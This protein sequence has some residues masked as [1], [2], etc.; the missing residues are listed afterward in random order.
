MT[1]AAPTVDGA[2]L[3]EARAAHAARP[4]DAA[5]LFRLACLLL[6]RADPEAAALLPA[7]ERFPGFAPGW[8]ALGGTLLR[9]GRAEAALLAFARAAAAAPRLA[10]ARR[11][12]AAALAALGRTAEAAEAAARAATL[13]P[14]D[15]EAWF[16]L[17][18]LRQDLG[19]PQAA[20]AAYAEALRLR[21]ALH[22]AAFN[23]G[24][25]LCDAGALEA[26]LDAFGAAFRSRP[27]S[28]GRIAQALVSGPSGCLFL[29]PE[30]LRAELV[31]RRAPGP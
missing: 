14:E 21:P 26:A 25:A 17:G 28:F 5:P 19:A 29:D 12:E 30:R 1:G 7:L 8:A 24:V 3:A 31:G 13:A 23:L 16:A 22:E 11:G 20:A 15:A 2:A 27:A 18:S 9:A 4:G 6:E 10:A